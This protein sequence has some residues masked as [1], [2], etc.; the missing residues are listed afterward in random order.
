MPLRLGLAAGLL[1]LSATALA[2][3]DA[4][5]LVGHLGKAVGAFEAARL[6]GEACDRREP[7]GAQMRKDALAAWRHDNLTDDYRRV[8]DGL[9]R[10]SPDIATQIDGQ[11]RK[12]AALIVEDLEKS[13]GQCRDFGKLLAGKQFDVKSAVRRLISLS[14]R[15]GVDT[16]APPPPPPRVQS[17]EAAEIQRLALLSA[18]LERTMAEIGSREG[19][20]R[21]PSLRRA[22]QDHAGRWLASEGLQL[23]FGRVTGER[24]L[25]EWRGDRQSLFAARCQSFANDAAAERMVASRGRD[26]VVAGSPRLVL[27]DAAGGRVT[28]DRCSLM[29]REEAGR[30]FADVPD[31]AGL[32]ARPL[33]AEEANAGPDRGIAPGEIDRILYASSFATR[34]DGFGNGY[35]DRGEAVYVLL[36][37]GTAYR[38]DWGFPVSDFAA[39]LSRRR[40]PE[41]WFTW[42]GQ[43]ERTVLTATGGAERGETIALG[44]AQALRPLTARRLE[45]RYRYLTVAAGGARG[46]R[47]ITFSAD[48][49]ATDRRDGFVA[50]NV[51]TSYMIVSG[52]RQPETTARYRIDGFAL[53]LATAQGEERRFLAVP[54]TAKGTP[55]D[56]ILIEGR[57]YWLRS[58]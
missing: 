35:V 28:L 25:R 49:T 42:R 30:P 10:R 39:A 8:L 46:E 45:G 4:D 41:R 55:P 56:T 23:L 20:R 3:Q 40:E 12:L 50:G 6:Y 54:E 17:L 34:M 29:T 36:R 48:G 2:A 38:H 52:A 18:R 37:D 19:A 51:G 13:P 32:T 43:G 16:A 58:D 9:V 1:A 47:H 57:A 53:V 5:E 21:S 44:E 22:R 24:E 33:S 27:D 15:L 31:E 7:D 26:M 14:R 11:S